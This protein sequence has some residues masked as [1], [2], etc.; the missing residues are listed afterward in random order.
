MVSQ[1]AER[2]GRLVHF[3]LTTGDTYTGR[4]P[5]IEM[6]RASNSFLEARQDVGVISTT[7]PAWT[8][9]SKTSMRGGSTPSAVRAVQTWL[10]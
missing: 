6:H 9:K 10:R 1:P 7:R 2:T 4:G 5:V 8:P 3:L